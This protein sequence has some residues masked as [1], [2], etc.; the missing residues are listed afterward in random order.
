MLMLYPLPA[1]ARPLEDTKDLPKD[2][3]ASTKMSAQEQGREV[4]NI[5]FQ[6]ILGVNINKAKTRVM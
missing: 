2:L 4:T 1:T 5:I 3:K 6:N